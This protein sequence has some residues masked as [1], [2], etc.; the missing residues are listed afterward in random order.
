MFWSGP[1]RRSRTGSRSSSTPRYMTFGYGAEQPA[2]VSVTVIRHLRSECVVCKDFCGLTDVHIACI[3]TNT[4]R[5]R[6]AGGARGHNVPRILVVDDDA[7]I[8][9]SIRSEERRVG[10]ECRS[11]WSA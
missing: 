9:D 7:T 3:V 1:A 2:R 6:A 8:R 5:W 10:K 11:R 4:L